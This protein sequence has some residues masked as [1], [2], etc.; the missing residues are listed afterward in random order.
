MP[1]ADPHHGQVA[2]ILCESLLHVLV[3][4]GVIKK[5]KAIE[6]I[7]TV[8]EVTRDLAERGDPAT[9]HN[10][11]VSLAETT[12]QSLR[13]KDC[14]YSMRSSPIGRR[15]QGHQSR[16]ISI[17]RCASAVGEGAMA[18]ASVHRRPAKRQLHR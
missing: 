4:E 7:D 3:E 16:G 10:A 14:S 12:A 11:A 2:L 17:T 8:I 18:I 6:A 1:A 5:E 9:T 13:V 15:R